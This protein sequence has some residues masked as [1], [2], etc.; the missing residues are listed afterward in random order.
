MN[1]TAV[2]P[3]TPTYLMLYPANAAKPANASNLNVTAGQIIPNLV[4][5]GLSP[6]GQVN[7]YN[8]SGQI[9]VLADVTGYY[10]SF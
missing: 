8:N 7:I 6:L 2:S 10:A 5:V 4:T 9:D 1:T 3:T